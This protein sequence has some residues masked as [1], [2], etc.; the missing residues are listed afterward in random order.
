M[1]ASVEAVAR[2]VVALR[3]AQVEGDAEVQSYFDRLAATAE[4]Y[5]IAKGVLPEE[6]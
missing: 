4:A 1:A 6:D 2:A 5:C 3:N